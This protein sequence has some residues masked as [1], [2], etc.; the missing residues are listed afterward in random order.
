VAVDAAALRSINSLKRALRSL[1]VTSVARIAARAAPAMSEL[2]QDA[3]ASGKTVYD[4]PRPRGVDGDA[5][6]LERTGATKRALQFVA[7][8]R[9]IRTAA[10]PRYARWLIGRYDILPN[11]PLPSAWRERLREVAARVLHDEIHRGGEP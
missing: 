9:D 10:L 3:H 5:L 2:A 8:G 7:T 6:S 11:G 1:P 4:R